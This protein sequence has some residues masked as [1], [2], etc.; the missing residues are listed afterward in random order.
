M[1][2][3]TAQAAGFKFIPYQP[4]KNDGDPARPPQPVLHAKNDPQL[5]LMRCGRRRL[6]SLGCPRKTA[7]Q[8]G[9]LYKRQRLVCHHKICES[10]KKLCVATK[11]GRALALT[12]RVSDGL[13]LAVAVQNFG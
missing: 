8:T 10:A 3:R 4:A 1:I 9:T 7:A 2:L 12:I 6:A 13:T 5:S 11:K